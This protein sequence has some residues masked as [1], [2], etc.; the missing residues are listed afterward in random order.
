MTT[1]AV[2]RTFVTVMTSFD[3]LLDLLD[4]RTIG[5]ARSASPTSRTCDGS[6]E[7]HLEARRQRVRVEVA[8]QVLPVL[9]SA[10]RARNWASAWSA[11]T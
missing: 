8:R 3:E 2:R 4:V 7:L 5:D 6:T 1:P 11:V 10:R 9:G